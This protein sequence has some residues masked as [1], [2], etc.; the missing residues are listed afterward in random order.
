MP[1]AGWVTTKKTTAGGGCYHHFRKG[2]STPLRKRMEGYHHC[3]RGGVQP[4]LNWVH[5][6]CTTATGRGYKMPLERGCHRCWVGQYAP[7]HNGRLNTPPIAD[8][9][10][11]LGGAYIITMWWCH[12]PCPGAKVAGMSATRRGRRGLFRGVGYCSV[13]QERGGNGCRI[14]YWEKKNAV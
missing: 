1:G 13:P 6:G 8:C 10:G 7:L 2:M 11:C 9:Q 5:H 4:L 14:S 12:Q 3:C